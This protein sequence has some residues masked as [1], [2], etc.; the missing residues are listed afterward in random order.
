MK[1]LGEKMKL[2]RART[3]Q[4]NI[5]YRLKDVNG[6]KAE[7]KEAAVMRSIKRKLREYQQDKMV[8]YY[9]S[10]DKV[11]ALAAALGCESY[12]HDV[13]D[14]EGRL[15]RFVT[16]KSR[17]M[18]ATNVLGI[19]IDIPDIRVV[20]HVDKP[21]TLLDYAQESGR[22]GRDGLKSETIMVIGWDV[23]RAADRHAYTLWKHCLLLAIYLG[24]AL[25]L[26]DI[27]RPFRS[28]W[29]LSS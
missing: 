5:R 13:E 6:Y 9:Y 14:R 11:K 25:I 1:F 29:S 18:V 23:L 26:I 3:R 19:R 7:E 8:V 16:G 28:G 17:V 24:N 22:A 15:E 27:R 10:V 4:R 12:Y 21:R 20:W 2:F